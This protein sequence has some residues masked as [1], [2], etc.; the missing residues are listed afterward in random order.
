MRCQAGAGFVSGA[1]LETPAA[2]FAFFG[3]GFEF[4]EM[5]FEVGFFTAVRE[6]GAFGVDAG[7]AFAGEGFGE[8]LASIVKEDEGIEA[9][10][11]KDG[12]P[13]GDHT[14]GATLEEALG[15][16]FG[17]EPYGDGLVA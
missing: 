2:A 17:F 7:E 15:V 14:E 1:G 16:S 9:T 10:A 11:F 13:A 5:A 12:L 3:F 8:F 4:L 6:V